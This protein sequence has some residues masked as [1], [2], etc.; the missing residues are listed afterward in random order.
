MRGEKE[1]HALFKPARGKK[2]KSGDE[3]STAAVDA[4]KEDAEESET[5]L[6]AELALD[7]EDV[8]HHLSETESELEEA[9]A[10]VIPSSSSSSKTPAFR[11]AREFKPRP[12][13]P[14][15]VVEDSDVDEV[16]IIA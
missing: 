7:D 14:E 8:W 3:T 5:E 10:K 1:I 16:E 2:R 6:A 4:A 12:A 15:V 13:G 11:K 9:P